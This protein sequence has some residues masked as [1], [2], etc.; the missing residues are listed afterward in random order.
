FDAY[1]ERFASAYAR[2]ANEQRLSAI[3]RVFLEEICASLGIATPLAWATDYEADGS[4]TERLVSLCVAAGASTYLSGPRARAYIEEK[5]FADAGIELE[6]MDYA[7]Y[8][9]YQQLYPPFDH[10]VTTLD[11]L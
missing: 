10:S 4:K 5:R 8:P 6:Y 7:G 11:L 9:E 3:N 1:A 2:A